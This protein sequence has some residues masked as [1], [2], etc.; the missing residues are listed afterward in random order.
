MIFELRQYRMFPGKRDE[1]VAFMDEVIIPG[2]TAAGATIHGVFVG[3]EEEDLYVWIRSFENEEQR[4]AF[5]KA[6][7]ETDEWINVLRPRVRE[8]I[9]STRNVVT[10]LTP[11]ANSPIQ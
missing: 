7:Y 1:W 6:Y 2:Q 8:M 3:L 9:D 4:A 5:T 10:L 11:T